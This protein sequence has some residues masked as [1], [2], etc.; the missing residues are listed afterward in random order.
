MGTVL[1]KDCAPLCGPRLHTCEERPWAWY[2]WQRGGRGFGG[3][4]VVQIRTR[5]EARSAEIIQERKGR[6]E[7]MKVEFREFNAA[8]LWVRDQLE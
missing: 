7:G 4:V 6:D 1:T 8:D 3:V 5:F 2:R